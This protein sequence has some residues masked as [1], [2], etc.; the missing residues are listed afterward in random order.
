MNKFTG[1]FFVLIVIVIITC[2]TV[3]PEVFFPEYTSHI[4]GTMTTKY[5]KIDYPKNG[6]NRLHFQLFGFER[7]SFLENKNEKLGLLYEAGVFVDN[8]IEE[9]AEV[10]EIDLKGFMVNIDIFPDDRDLRQVCGEFQMN[11]GDMIDG[12]PTII[13]GRGC[14]S[15]IL[16]T[17]YLSNESFEAETLIHEVAHKMI[18]LKH[19]K[20]MSKDQKE[21][22]V[23]G[24]TKWMVTR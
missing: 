3:G 16:N 17:V 19:G 1:A 6:V 11:T 12:M 4:A 18:H 8:L 2:I 5:S 14:Y 7:R 10:I 24:I 9:T 20:S 21:A 15:N 23:M 22:R 13:I